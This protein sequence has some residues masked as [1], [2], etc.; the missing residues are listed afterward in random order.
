MINKRFNNDAQS[1]VAVAERCLI[2]A[3]VDKT[4]LEQGCNEERELFLE[5][6]APGLV[7]AAAHGTNLAFLT[8]NSMPGIVW[9]S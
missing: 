2:A 7:N 9:M 3:D 4:I 5:K 8:G 6:V 1:R